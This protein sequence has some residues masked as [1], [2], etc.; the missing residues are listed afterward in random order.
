MICWAIAQ[1][2]HAQNCVSKL[3]TKFISKPFRTGCIAAPPVPPT[4]TPISTAERALT[5]AGRQKKA[6]CANSTSTLPTASQLVSVLRKRYAGRKQ[7]VPVGIWEPS[8]MMR[9]LSMMEAHTGTRQN[10][11]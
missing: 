6:I 1:P 9:I 3:G 4:P 7:K 8:F 2:K 5:P 10:A 11:M